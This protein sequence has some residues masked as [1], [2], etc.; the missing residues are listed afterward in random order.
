MVRGGERDP[1][2]EKFWREVLERLAN[3]GLPQSQFCIREG[4][5]QRTLSSWKGIVR[6]RD[7]ELRDGIP[8]RR[9]RWQ[10][11][12]S[13]SSFIP[14]ITKIKKPLAT[15]RES[16]NLSVD[17]QIGEWS[18]H[19]SCGSDIDNLKSLLSVLRELSN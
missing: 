10:A 19:V 3:S 11:K 13:K 8:R 15:S 2:K 16:T 6:D 7:A 1:E 4:L 17:L 9:K 14:V 12:A 5:N 18:A